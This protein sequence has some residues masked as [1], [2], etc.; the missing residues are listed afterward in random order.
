MR[1]LT[2]FMIKIDFHSA[3]PKMGFKSGENNWELVREFEQCG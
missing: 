2:E 1:V 3:K